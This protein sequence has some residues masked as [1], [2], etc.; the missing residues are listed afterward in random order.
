MTN[1]T[2][3]ETKLTVF[4][5]DSSMPPRLWV[6]NMTRSRRVV[7]VCFLIGTVA[8]YVL[9][10]CAKTSLKPEYN[11]VVP[12]EMPC[13]SRSD[14]Q[15]SY[16]DLQGSD[17]NVAKMPSAVALAFASSSE[18]WIAN[19]RETVQKTGQV[20]L[21][22]LPGR[23]VIGQRELGELS[24]TH[25][26]FNGDGALIATPNQVSCPPD[27]SK[28]FKVC[29]KVF[30]WR[31]ATGELLSADRN[32]WGEI[33]D[34]AFDTQGRWILTADG[35]V[36]IYDP[37]QLFGGFGW[38]PAGAR[39]NQTEYVVAGTLSPTGNLI[40]YGTSQKGLGIE[41]WNGV[42]FIHPYQWTFISVKSEGSAK[43]SIN[44]I[45]LELAISPSNHWLAILSKSQ[46][47]LRDITSAA[48]SQHGKTEFH[49]G[50]NRALVF[51]PSSSLV[52]VGYSQGL[53]VYS[54]PELKLL[55]DTP[56]AQATSVAFSP[57]GCLLAWGDV[58]GTVHIINAPKP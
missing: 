58:E 37:R 55:A 41:G 40:A 22:S 48:L 56:G 32:P 53:R 49:V 57:D 44:E 12:A 16:T 54:V 20:F 19:S 27:L 46:I 36:N 10:G 50:T 42:E 29:Q 7:L 35:S 51:N 8:L 14:I 4:E 47:E 6:H 9:T 38:L 5:K 2:R 17:P 33:V 52:A 30:L 11:S 3:W 26:R 15:F 31:T 34:M 13:N 23:Q 39:E 1:L 45:P 25:T 24:P 28:W 21:V 43:K 18:L